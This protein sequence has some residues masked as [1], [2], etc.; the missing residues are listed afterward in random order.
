MPGKPRRKVKGAQTVFESIR[1]RV[2]P[3]AKPIGQPKPD[4]RARPARRKA[5]HKGRAQNAASESED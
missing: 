4:E 2:A 3:P 5:K 1:K